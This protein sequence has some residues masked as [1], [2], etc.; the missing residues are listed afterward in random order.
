MDT[1]LN[2]PFNKSSA[3]AEH[4]SNNY[5]CVRYYNNVIFQF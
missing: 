3:I 5:D 2:K 1:G 4:L